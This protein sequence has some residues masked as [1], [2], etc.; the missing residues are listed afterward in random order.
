MSKT[1]PQHTCRGRHLAVVPDPATALRREQQRAPKS[2]IGPHG[3]LD[4]EQ[5]CQFVMEL[6]LMTAGVDPLPAM[7]LL[8]RCAEHA[9]RCLT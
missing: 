1:I 2:S 3:R 4:V 5:A 6:D 7:F 9:R 8:G